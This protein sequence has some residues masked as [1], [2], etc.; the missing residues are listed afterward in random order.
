MADDSPNTTKLDAVNTMLGTIGE[1]SLTSLD[2]TLPADAVTAQK[3]L[4]EISRTVQT[5]G[6]DFNTIERVEFP[7]DVGGEIPIAGSVLRAD[8]RRGLTDDV[9]RG[10]KLYNKTNQTFIYTSAKTA[11]EVVYFLQWD[12]LPEEARRYIEIRAA[13]VFSQRTIGSAELRG[14]TAEDEREAKGVLV[15]AQIESGNYNFISTAAAGLTP[16]R[17]RP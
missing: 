13:R 8:F 5:K 2:G 1:A 11:D 4:L 17:R 16:P 14:F 9:K 10:A 12:D 15:A 6:W 3:V 7:M